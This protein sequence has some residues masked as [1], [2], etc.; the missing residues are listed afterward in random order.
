MRIGTLVGKT[1]DGDF[2][3]IGK[4]GPVAAL[5]AMQRKLTNENGVHDGKKLVKTY[6]ADASRNPLKVRKCAKGEAK[7]AAKKRASKK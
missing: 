1:E 5:D 4:P 6:L 2:V 7:P 3:Y